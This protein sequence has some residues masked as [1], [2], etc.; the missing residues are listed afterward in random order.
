MSTYTFR[1]IQSDRQL[2]VALAAMPP[3]TRKLIIAHLDADSRNRLARHTQL[4]ILGK[5]KF[6]LPPDRRQQFR[7]TLGRHRRRV[8]RFLDLPL[9]AESAAARKKK[10]KQSG[11]AGFLPFLLSAVLPI[12]ASIITGRQSKNSAASAG[13]A[14]KKGAPAE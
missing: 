4:F 9:G 7:E 12:I 8:Q 13:A 6:K 2:A 14:G 5:G 11:A 10:I 1:A 3:P